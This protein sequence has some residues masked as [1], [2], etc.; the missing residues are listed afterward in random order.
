MRNEQSQ[1]AMSNE[2]RKREEGKVGRRNEE[3]GMSNEQ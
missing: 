2:Q 1:R 3:V